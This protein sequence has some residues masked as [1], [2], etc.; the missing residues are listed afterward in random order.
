MIESIENIKALSKKEYDHHRTAQLLYGHLVITLH[1][2]PFGTA[3]ASD[4]AIHLEHVNQS[5]ITAMCI[6]LQSRENYQK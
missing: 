3:S 6:C 1:C 4:N 5:Y 2:E